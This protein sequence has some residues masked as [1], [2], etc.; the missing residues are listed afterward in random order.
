MENTKLIEDDSE[1]LEDESELVPVIRVVPDPLGR[2]VL[3]FFTG[4]PSLIPPIKRRQERKH[5]VDYREHRREFWRTAMAEVA[6]PARVNRRGE[7][8]DD[9]K[10]DDGGKHEIE[11][12]IKYV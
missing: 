8:P 6:R 2:R 7:D 9:W 11:A 10:L 3:N 4:L 5:W 12:D 1:F